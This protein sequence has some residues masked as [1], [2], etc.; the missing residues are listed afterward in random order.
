MI[1][2]AHRGNTTGPN[3]AMENNPEY[4]D[5][6]LKKGYHVEVDLFYDD[7]YGWRLGHDTPRYEIDWEWLVDDMRI[8]RLW[9]HCKNLWALQ[10]LTYKRSVGPR[11]SYLN[12][13]YHERDHATIT[14]NGYLW[15][16]PGVHNEA[17][18][19]DKYNKRPAG[20]AVMPPKDMNLKYFAGVCTDDVE[21]YKSVDWNK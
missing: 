18:Y 13:F 12:F 6:A 19:Q 20:I 15:F 4:V 21:F 11:G 5:A 8:D 7:T 1:L 17:G 9:I 16:Y 10:E 3:H 14:S 2:I